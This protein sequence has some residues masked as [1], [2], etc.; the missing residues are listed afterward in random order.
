MVPGPSAGWMQLG[1]Q[2]GAQGRHGGTI[3]LWRGGWGGSLAPIWPCGAGEGGQTSPTGR[4]REV[5]RKGT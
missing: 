3:Q 4:G 1:S 2:S 5:G